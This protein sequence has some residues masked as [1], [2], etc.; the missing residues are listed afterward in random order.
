MSVI[1]SGFELFGEHK[2]NPSWEIM[3]KFNGQRF[4]DLTCHSYLLP[5]EYGAGLADCLGRG[6]LARYTH[7][8]MPVMPRD[9]T[10]KSDHCGSLIISETRTRSPCPGRVRELLPQLWAGH[11]DAALCIHCGV[12][13]PGAVKLETRAR[14]GPYVRLDNAAAAPSDATCCAGAAAQ[15]TTTL[16]VQR[17]LDAALAADAGTHIAASSDA[18]LF[19]CEFAYFGSLAL[20]R[21]PVLFVHVPPLGSPYSLDALRL[22]VHRIIAAAVAQ[23]RPPAP[24]RPKVPVPDHAPRLSMWQVGV[25]VL[26]TS[27]THPGHVLVGR[28]RG[29]FAAGTY[30]LP[31]GHLE[32]GESFEVCAA[33]E[34]AEECGVVL[35]DAAVVPFT[36]NAVSAS[37]GFHCVVPFVRGQCSDEPR[38]MEPDKCDGWQWCVFPDGIPQPRFPS[39]QQFIDAG[40]TL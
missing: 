10:H 25:A 22:I 28:R 21:A 34:V 14:N 38:N 1:L 37:D 35:A 13:A 36:V 5:V 12:G 27:A 7:T 31:G 33:R 6:S 40:F 15:I 24:P 8:W 19:L 30:A 20:G 23:I 4:G 29:G 3:K 26:V 11:T 32:F 17:I 39:L 9:A 16:D 18:G 2:I